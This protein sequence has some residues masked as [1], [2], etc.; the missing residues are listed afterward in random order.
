MSLI[1]S[2]FIWYVKER[3]V[4]DI[5]KKAM[6][7]YLVTKGLDSNTAK[8]VSNDRAENSFSGESF[9]SLIQEKRGLLG[10]KQAMQHAA[11]YL[12]YVK[13]LSSYPYERVKALVALLAN[14][15][16]DNATI[17]S[18][19][20]DSQYFEPDKIKILLED[21]GVKESLEDQFFRSKSKK[22]GIFSFFS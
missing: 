21:K 13:G 6:A 12:L 4:M 10:K 3:N 5:N 18:I 17:D 16:G 8:K 14:R 20:G 9:L 22:G 1:Q 15:Y 11:E 19:L 2:N 7:G